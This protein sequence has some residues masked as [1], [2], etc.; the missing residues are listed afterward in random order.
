MTTEEYIVYAA[1]KYELPE[2]VVARIL[3]GYLSVLNNKGA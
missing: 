1:K 2:A 3:M